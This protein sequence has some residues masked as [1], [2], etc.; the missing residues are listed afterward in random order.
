ML[1]V[2]FALFLLDMSHS[3]NGIFRIGSFQF[4]QG[5][6]ELA[7]EESTRMIGSNSDGES[8]VGPP[9]GE[10]VHVVGDLNVSAVLSPRNVLGSSDDTLPLLGESYD[11]RQTRGIRQRQ[12]SDTPRP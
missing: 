11:V 6:D 10:R 8:H 9:V 2:R 7:A 4:G 1:I 12:F 5:V 3:I